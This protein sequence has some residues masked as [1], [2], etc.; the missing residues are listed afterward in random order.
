MYIHEK[1]FERKQN[2]FDALR[3]LAAL[4]VFASHATMYQRPYK[5]EPLELLTDGKF[6]LSSCG[7][8]IFFTLS[9]FLVCRSLSQT[10]VKDYLRNRLL[11]IIPGIS[12]CTLLTVLVT[13][14]FFT[15]LPF[16]Q[17]ITHVQTWH[18]L[19][20]NALPFRVVFTLPGAFD[21]RSVNSSLWTIPL[22]LKLYCLL[23]IGYLL[24][25]SSLRIAIGIVWCSILLASLMTK[26]FPGTFAQSIQA[27]LPERT[28]ITYFMSG[29]FFYIFRDKIPVKGTIW[30]ALLIVWLFALKVFPAY[31]SVPTV[32]FFVYTVICIGVCKPMVY[33]GTAD[34]SYGFYLYSYPV[35]LCVD[36]AW[37]HQMKYWQF[38]T[39]TL[40]ITLILAVASWHVVEKKALSLK[41]H[42][43]PVAIEKLV[44]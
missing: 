40:A 27:F 38:N 26:L 37:G 11:R 7:L 39:I 18:F 19:A 21:G 31:S 9:G 42:R 5:G 8:Y 20:Q 29:A 4:M 12:V 3:L 34:I 15:T 43:R 17:F 35:Q 41:K 25:G 44:A 23:L 2:N 14:L 1:T 30:L 36:Q 10:T 13:G 33:L 24:K 6:H 28:L 22:E 16:V 32:L